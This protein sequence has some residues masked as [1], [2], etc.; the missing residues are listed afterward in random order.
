MNKLKIKIGI[1]GYGYVGKAFYNFFKTHYDVSIYDPSYEKSCTKE[2]INNCD[3]GVICVPTPQKK[4]GGCDISIVEES[5]KWM[6]NKIILCKSTVPPSTTKTLSEKYNKSIVFSPEY[7][8]ESSYWTPYKFHTDV[9]ETPFF[10]FGGE[11]SACEQLIDIYIPI[12]GPTKTYRIT[13]S[14]SAELAKYAENS[15]YAT[16]VTFCNE[17]FDICKK[18]NSSWNEVRELFLLDPRINPMHTMVL[19][20]NRGFGGKCF[21][22]DVNAIIEYAKSIGVNPQL[23]ESV[24]STN[25]RIRKENE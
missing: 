25:N 13:D 4:D 8:G 15:F 12:T 24:I 5:V 10:I 17:F 16:K 20:D 23:L 14:T 6:N 3:I 18:S 2:E 7:A 19:K 22:K 9:K 21:P 1:V 11:K